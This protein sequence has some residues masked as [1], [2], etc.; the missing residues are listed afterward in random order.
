MSQ[1]S[2]GPF[3]HGTGKPI[4]SKPIFIWEPAYDVDEIFDCGWSSFDLNHGSYGI[5]PRRL[6][7]E[8]YHRCP[9]EPGAVLDQIVDADRAR[10]CV[11]DIQ[12][13]PIW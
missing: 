11:I 9:D 8:R 5:G 6:R 1:A 10:L 12:A 3:L 2:W 4:F 13:P 7:T